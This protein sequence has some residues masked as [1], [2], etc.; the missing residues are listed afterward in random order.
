MGGNC[1]VFG[2]FCIAI[3]PTL[4]ECANGAHANAPYT[5]KVER[6]ITR[7]QGVLA[8]PKVKAHIQQLKAQNKAK[9]I[10]GMKLLDRANALLLSNRCGYM[11]QE[12]QAKDAQMAETMVRSGRRL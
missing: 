6:T 7:V 5:A 11:A 10:S 8:R 4:R 1:L 3:S 9:E 2:S 12:R